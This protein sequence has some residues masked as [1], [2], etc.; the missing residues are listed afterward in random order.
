MV[1]SG[2]VTDHYTVLQVHP[3]ADR[4]VIEAAYR[5]LMKK[6]HPDMAG[7]D[8]EMAALY[9]QRAKAI[10]EAYGVLRDPE[11]RLRY[12]RDRIVVGTRPPPRSDWGNP[13]AAVPPRPGP[14][15][16]APPPPAPSPEVVQ[17]GG[18][19]AVIGAPFALLSAAYYLLPGPYEWDKGRR[20]EVLIALLVPGLGVTG[21][22]LATGRLAPLIGHGLN[23][24]LLA[25][26]LLVLLSIPTWHSLPR[27]AMA[28]VP[29]LLMF[30]GDATALLRQA[31]LPFWFTWALVG[32]LSLVLS[33]RLYVFSVL[34]TLAACWLLTRFT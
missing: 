25:W 17:P 23:A 30:Y 28:T 24:N 29:S 32:V 34:P 1:G 15:P 7:D 22:A 10:N 13:S 16:P 8:V 31:N 11:T 26:G 27:I 19:L 5:Q 9:H 20:Q 12:D 33:A 2:L 21:F 6:Y 14:K 18:L 4:E 3:D